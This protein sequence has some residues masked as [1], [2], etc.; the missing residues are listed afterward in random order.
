[1]KKIILLLMS[2]LFVFVC[3]YADDFQYNFIENNSETNM[4]VILNDAKDAIHD[5]SQTVELNE[6]TFVGQIQSVMNYFL[7]M[8]AFLALVVIMYWFYLIL[9]SGKWEEAV[10]KAKKYLFWW[11]I[12]LVVSWISWYIV[13][14][15]FHIFETTK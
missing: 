13:S 9:F 11:I 7:W 10:W 12:A 6:T 4:W 15:M 3:V 14:I 2:L 8:I 5:F 1:M